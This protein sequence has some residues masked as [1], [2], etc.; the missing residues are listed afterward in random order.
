[1]ATDH[2]SSAISPGA[3]STPQQ[4]VIPGQIAQ[5]RGGREEAATPPKYRA[6]NARERAFGADD[7]AEHANWPRKCVRVDLDRDG[8][9]QAK[10]MLGTG[11]TRKRVRVSRS[12]SLAA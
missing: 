8:F 3:G 1:V 4:T 5:T 10:K 6:R 2:A 7:P 11:M 9:E 12:T